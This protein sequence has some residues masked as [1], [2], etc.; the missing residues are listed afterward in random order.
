MSWTFRDVVKGLKP[1]LAKMSGMSPQF[2]KGAT[3][4]STMVF[5]LGAL[6]TGA[7]KLDLIT[8]SGPFPLLEGKSFCFVL[9]KI[10]GL[11]LSALKN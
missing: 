9:F 2:D 10:Q 11:A 6:L 4:K 8:L 3:G 1:T 5:N 7:D